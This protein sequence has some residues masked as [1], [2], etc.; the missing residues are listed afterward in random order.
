MTPRI[1][2]LLVTLTCIAGCGGDH[3][4]ELDHLVN[5]VWME[6]FPHEDAVAF[7]E[8]GGT[9]YDTKYGDFEDVDREYV[10]PL[11]KQ[12]NDVTGVPALAFIDED[13]NWAWALIVRVSDEGA[14]RSRV[15]SLIA[16]AEAEYPGVI[17]AEWGRTTLRISFVDESEHQSQDEPVE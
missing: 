8:S 3:A 13:L 7:L 5:T 6:D 14:A 12:I 4:A 10:V 11:L 16:D 1:T 17:E 15:Q 9:H 2:T